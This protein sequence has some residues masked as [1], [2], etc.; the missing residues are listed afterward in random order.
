[1]KVAN[2]FLQQSG[3]DHLRDVMARKAKEISQMVLKFKEQSIKNLF[4]KHFNRNTL[5]EIKEFCQNH[6]LHRVTIQNDPDEYIIIDG[7][8]YLRFIMQFNPVAMSWTISEA[9]YIPPQKSTWNLDETPGNLI[10]TSSN[11]D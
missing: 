8:I 2:E 11:F 7:L 9:E 5:Q 10:D 4:A 1:M 6:R 3:S